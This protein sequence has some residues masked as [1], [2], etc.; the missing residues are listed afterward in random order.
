MNLGVTHDLCHVEESETLDYPVTI[1]AKDKD[2]LKVTKSTRGVKNSNVL[3][4]SI[5]ILRWF[6]L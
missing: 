3:G 2:L 5:S 4:R 6:I 1:E